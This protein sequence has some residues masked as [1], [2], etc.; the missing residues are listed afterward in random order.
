MLESNFFYKV[1]IDNVSTLGEAH[2]GS[3]IK[4]IN[5]VNVQGD[6]GHTYSITEY[7]LFGD[8]SLKIGGKLRPSNI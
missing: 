3:I 1:G 5:D 2:S 7:Q 8:P 4:Y 6:S